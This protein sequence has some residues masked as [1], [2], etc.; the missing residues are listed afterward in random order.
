GAAMN[1]LGI[2]R[3]GAH[4]YAMV[5]AGS[6][7][8]TVYEFTTADATVAQYSGPAVSGSYSFVMGALDPASGIFYLGTYSA[9]GVDLYGFDT[10][11]NTAIGGRIAQ[12]QL[13]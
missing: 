12:V 7:S 1:A 6:G 5:S 4:A 3:D 8:S 9:A 10:G 2:T 11:T 13:P